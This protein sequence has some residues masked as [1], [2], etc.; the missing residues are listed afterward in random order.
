[1][2]EMRNGGGWETLCTFVRA[3]C[4]DYRYTGVIIEYEKTTYLIPFR[5]T[6]VG[7]PEQQGYRRPG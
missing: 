5:L 7:Q 2:V 1:M 6:F 4:S 3:R